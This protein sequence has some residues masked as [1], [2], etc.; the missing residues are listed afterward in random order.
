MPHSRAAVAASGTV[1]LHDNTDGGAKV[2]VIGDG[3]A[4]QLA[5]SLAGNL[6]YASDSPEPEP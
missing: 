1:T 6:G 4:G 2:A 5:I 3:T